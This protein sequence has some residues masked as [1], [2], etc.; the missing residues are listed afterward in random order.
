MEISLPSE[1]AFYFPP[2]TSLDIARVRVDS[3][4]INLVVGTM[5][6]LWSRPKPEEV[7]LISTENRL[8]PFW[9]VVIS[10][11]TTYE[12]NRTYTVS[13]GGPEI[14]SITVLG[15]DIAI[16][17]KAKA[18]PGFTL[19]AVEHCREERRLGQTY[20]GLSGQKAN[21]GSYLTFPKEEITDLNNFA[22][23]GVLVVPAQARATAVVR[24]LMAEV[25]KPVQAQVIHEERVDVEAI[26]LLFHPV[27]AFEYEW[28]AKGKKLVIEYDALTEEIRTGGKKWSDQIKNVL[29]RDVLFDM[30]ADAVGMVVPGGSIAVKLVKAVV[31]RAK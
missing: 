24:Q 23:P 9:H 22:A 30:T 14:Y 21:L 25:I 19:S 6:A 31:D 26:D 7:Q 8:E 12:R 5:S 27:Y 16:D 13:V 29:T 2:Q 15:Q 4:R 17:P 1:R 20:D 18:G 3:K 11:H 28:A 10:A